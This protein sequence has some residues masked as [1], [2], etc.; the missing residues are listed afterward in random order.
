MAAAVKLKHLIESKKMEIYSKPLI[1]ELKTYV[2]TGLGFKAKVGEHDD[3]VSACLLICRMAAV[4][5]DFDPDVYQSISDRMDN[6]D[7]PMPIYI[8]SYF[9]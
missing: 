1:S 5:A 9:W 3:L 8:S 6:E 7:L 2:A 4:L